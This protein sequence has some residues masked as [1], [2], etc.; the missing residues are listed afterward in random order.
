M[1]TKKTSPANLG[2]PWHIGLSQCDGVYDGEQHWAV[3]AS[4]CGGVVADVEGGQTAQTQA[5]AEFIVQACNNHEELLT[6]CQM[7]RQDAEDAITGRWQPTVEG[8]ES[9]IE[10]LTRV[11]GNA[12]GNAS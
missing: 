6:A 4:D 8:W 1:A 12:G 11:I 7:C 9:I 5:K 2:L 3:L 10:H